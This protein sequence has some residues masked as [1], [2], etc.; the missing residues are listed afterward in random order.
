MKT[1]EIVWK[2]KV[3]SSVRG[4]E[5][6]LRVW[7]FHRDLRVDAPQ[8]CW[9]KTQ[10]EASLHWLAQCDSWH[11]QAVN[12]C[13]IS[14]SLSAPGQH[15]LRLLI[16][17]TYTALKTY[18]YYTY[19]GFPCWTRDENCVLKQIKGPQGSESAPTGSVRSPLHPKEVSP[20]NNPTVSVRSALA[21]T[22]RFA[23]SAPPRCFLLRSKVYKILPRLQ[24]CVSI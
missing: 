18:V 4:E 2:P 1:V 21:P 3:K 20:S 6:K 9:S 19:E 15:R 11:N 17:C 16:V 22:N 23:G 13:Q 12:K 7:H 10:L 14:F 24:H 8:E 5:W